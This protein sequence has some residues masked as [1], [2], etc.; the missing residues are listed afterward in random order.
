MPPEEHA[1]TAPLV[2]VII[3]TRDSASTVLAA[4]QSVREQDVAAEVVI[5]DSGSGDETLHLV[6]DVV[7]RIEQVPAH[8]F[9]YGGSLNI[10]AAVA[11]APVHVALSSHCVLPRTDWLRIAASHVLEEGAAA[12]VG[13]P[14]DADR[15]RLDAPFSADYDYVTAHR[16]WGFSNHASAWDAKVWQRH[17]FD[18]ELTASEDKEWTW[19]ALADSGPLVVDPDLIVAGVHRRSAGV[20]PYFARLVKEI[21]SVEHLRPTPPYGLGA[22]LADWTRAKPH[23]RYISGARRLGRTRLVEV[24]ARW[25]AGRAGRSGRD[26]EPERRS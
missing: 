4:V 16:H 14:F 21:R 2:S 23:D 25:L 18:E 11:S 1:A 17:H 9:S 7:D 26:T 13:L 6:Q 20:R 24:T 19:R 12:V 22:A 5:V 8:E 3:R 10:G 15:H